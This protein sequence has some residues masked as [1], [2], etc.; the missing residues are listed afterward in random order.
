MT[1]FQLDQCMNDRRLAAAC[2]EQ[3]LATAWRFPKRLVDALDPEVLAD[4]LGKGNPLVT[5]DQRFAR[6]HVACIPSQNPGIITISNIRGGNPKTMTTALAGQILG[7]FKSLFPN[8]HET[9]LRNSVIEITPAGVEVWHAQDGKLIRDGYHAFDDAGW[10]QALSK[11]L[12]QNAA[13][14]ID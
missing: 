9:P 10:D 12:F 7:R 8:W 5:F 14:E 4:L 6:D 13:R 11:L 2:N 1:T 3:G